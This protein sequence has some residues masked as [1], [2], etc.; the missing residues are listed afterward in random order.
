M[1]VLFANKKLTLGMLFAW[2]GLAVVIATVGA[3]SKSSLAETRDL[4]STEEELS[5][6]KSRVSELKAQLVDTDAIG[7][8]LIEDV[9]NLEGQIE[10]LKQHRKDA[11]FER[12]AVLAEIVYMEELKSELVSAIQAAEAVR[13]ALLESLAKIESSTEV[14]VGIAE[15]VLAELKKK[16]A[17]AKATYSSNVS[18]LARLNNRIAAASSK[19]DQVDAQVESAQSALS[20]ART[21]IS[22]AQNQQRQLAKTK[23][24]LQ[25]KIDKLEDREKQLRAEVKSLESEAGVKQKSPKDIEILCPEPWK[26]DPRGPLVKLQGL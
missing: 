1:S 2:F 15:S 7:P 23:A 21:R 5:R 18:E 19:L 22:N 8:E 14:N 25:L 3:V 4:V 16:H 20:S 17:Q 12:D 13:N 26:I 11:L 10:T 6:V 24:S 9:R